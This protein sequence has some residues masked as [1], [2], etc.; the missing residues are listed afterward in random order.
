MEIK[1]QKCNETK[2]END[3]RYVKNN[4]IIYF[5]V[6]RCKKCFS[7]GKNKYNIYIKPLN[8][9][10]LTIKYFGIEKIMREDVKRDAYLLLKRIEMNKGYVDNFDCIRIVDI[11]NEIYGEVYT[12]LDR[13]YEILYFFEKIKEFSNG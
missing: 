3:F 6:G 1:C 2:T 9:E 4:N 8:L 13:E 11:H 7:N 10:G 12:K 5:N